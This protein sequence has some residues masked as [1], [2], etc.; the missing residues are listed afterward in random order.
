[1][2]FRGT[3]R[4]NGA[5]YTTLYVIIYVERCKNPNDDSMCTA[6]TVGDSYLEFHDATK[7]LEEEGFSGGEWQPNEDGGYYCMYKDGCVAQVQYTE[8]Q[9]PSDDD[10]DDDY[11]YDYDEG[12]DDDEGDED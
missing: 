12:D 8:I 2:Y 5:G 3:Q 11:Y 7:A 9:L 6:V 1:M 4:Y 10:D